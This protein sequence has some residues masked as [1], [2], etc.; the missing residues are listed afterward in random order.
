MPHD[1]AEHLGDL[2]SD[3]DGELALVDPAQAA[4]EVLHLGDEFLE[5]EGEGLGEGQR[6]EVGQVGLG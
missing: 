4:D 2:P 6:E 5:V 1:L 3:Q